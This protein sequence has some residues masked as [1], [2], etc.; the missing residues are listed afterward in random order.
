MKFKTIA[1]SAIF[2]S[3]LAAPAIASMGSGANSLPLLEEGV[4]A[5]QILANGNPK[6]FQINIERPT[7][8]KVTSENF[9]G[10]SSQG[11]Y[12][13]ATLYDESGATVA[14]SSDPRGHFQL[15]RRLQPGNYQLEISGSSAGGNT[16]ASGNRYE[17][18]VAY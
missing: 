13:M 12:I 6:R 4:S 1:F 3:M 2:A 10:V 8:L 11:N 18:H 7:T 16:E 14:Q 5:S 17:L 9:T 15:N